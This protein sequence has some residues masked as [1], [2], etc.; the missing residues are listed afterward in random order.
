MGNS[1]IK[2]VSMSSKV[3]PGYWKMGREQGVIIAEGNKMQ[4]K[5]FVSF[6][7]PDIDAKYGFELEF[8][9]FG[10]ARKELAEAGGKTNLNIY[11]KSDF[12]SFKGIVNDEGTEILMWESELVTWHHLPEEELKQLMEDRTP[13]HT[14][15]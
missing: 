2:P 9:D 3:Q 8:G 13:Y 11:V 10:E 5:N 12:F 4:V 14:P 6:D 7:Y 1:C 15:R